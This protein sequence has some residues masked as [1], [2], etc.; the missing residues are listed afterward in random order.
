MVWVSPADIDRTRNTN[1][2][3]HPGRPE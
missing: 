2:R 1:G 3:L